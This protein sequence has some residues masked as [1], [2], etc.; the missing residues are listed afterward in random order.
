MSGGVVIK[1]GFVGKR[2]RGSCG[3]KRPRGRSDG[4][5]ASGLARRPVKLSGRLSCVGRRQPAFISLSRFFPPLTLG[6]V[7]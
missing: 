4:D 5:G 6:L 2:H 1:R 3:V 7:Q